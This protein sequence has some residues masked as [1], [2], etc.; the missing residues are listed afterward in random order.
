MKFSHT[1]I[2]ALLA[3]STVISAAPAAV[4]T[5][6]VLHIQKRSQELTLLMDDLTALK[7]RGDLNEDEIAKREYVLVTQLLTLLKQTGLTPT[8]LKWIVTNGIFQPIIVDVI[9]GL[10]KSGAIDWNALFV[11]LDKSGLAAATIQGLISDCKFYVALFDLAKSFIQDLIPKVNSQITA[12]ISTRDLLAVDTMYHTREDSFTDNLEIRATP[13]DGVIINLLESV[14][15]S[16]LATQVVNALFTDPAYR[17]FISALIQE[18][19]AEKALNLSE[20]L[21]ALIESGLVTSLLKQFLN[22]KTFDTIIT[23]AFAAFSGTCGQ[24]Q[25]S[26][27]GSPTLAISSSA[28]GTTPTGTPSNCRR[29]R[30]S[31]NY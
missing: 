29:R 11:A 17:P 22:A 18:I 25:S 3:C 16:G 26:G 6:D 7:K 19:I 24:V 4:V 20:I 2:A 15:N 27:G 21:G 10:L 14:A 31:Y 13:E 9:V 1:T 23:N 28:G 5:N 12:S 30:R 8:I